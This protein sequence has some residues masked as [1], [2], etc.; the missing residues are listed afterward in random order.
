MEMW[1]ESQQNSK[2]ARSFA[3]EQIQRGSQILG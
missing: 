3:E 1:Q 2:E